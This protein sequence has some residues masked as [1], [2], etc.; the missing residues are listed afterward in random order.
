[1]Q[2]L[3]TGLLVLTVVTTSAL[4]QSPAPVRR[5]AKNP[6][7][8]PNIIDLESTGRQPNTAP[9]GQ[10]DPQ[11]QPAQAVREDQMELLIRTVGSLA[12]EM[13][14]LVH[15]IRAM[16]LRQQAQIDLARLSG[17]ATRI[18]ALS[19]DLRSL[20]D[21]AN[22]LAVDEQNLLQMMTRESLLAQSAN[23]GSLDRERTMEQIRATHEARLRYVQAEK[24]RLRGLETDLLGQLQQQ[25]AQQQ[26]AEKRILASEEQIRRLE[27]GREEPKQDPKPQP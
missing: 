1:M 13:R 26:D 2:Y 3:L 7:Q 16:N 5:P 17:V 18:D 27:A 4:A 19:A 25:L 11:V 23:I 14:A 10:P 24:D 15:E 9:T 20:R 8:Y 12:G 22:S 6:P 21:R